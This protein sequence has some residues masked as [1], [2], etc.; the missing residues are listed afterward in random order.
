MQ[1]MRCT[2]EE[3]ES[4]KI[5]LDLEAAAMKMCSKG[6]EVPSKNKKELQKEASK[7]LESIKEAHI[8]H[9]KET[10]MGSS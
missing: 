9:K 2:F 10:R 5:K 3:P 8:Q 7:Y 4:K 1:S 6:K